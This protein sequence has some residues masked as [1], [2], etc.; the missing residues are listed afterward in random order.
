MFA[1]LSYLFPADN[2]SQEETARQVEVLREADK[3]K[4]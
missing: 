2:V 4:K 1:E 3:Q